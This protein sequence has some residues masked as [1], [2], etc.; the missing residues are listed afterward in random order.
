MNRQAVG[1]V[2][3]KSV[4]EHRHCELLPSSLLSHSPSFREDNGRRTFGV[5]KE[6]A[7][8]TR[9]ALTSPHSKP[10]PPLVLIRGLVLA[11]V[12]GT[13]SW[14]S[15]TQL[16]LLP[17]NSVSAS[18]RRPQSSSP[19]ANH[20][21]EHRRGRRRRRVSVAESSTRFRVDSRRAQAPDDRVVVDSNFSFNARVNYLLDEAK[22]TAFGVSACESYCHSYENPDVRRLSFADSNSDWK[23]RLPSQ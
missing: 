16:P 10:I 12:R 15:S 7:G 1:H 4:T 23:R 5:R 19:A 6:N 20:S 2:R 21:P 11:Q 17:L 13:P 14:F 18:R 9:L 22:K 3:K 8:S